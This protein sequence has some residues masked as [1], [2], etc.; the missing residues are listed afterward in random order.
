MT[1]VQTC[2]LPILTGMNLLQVW[3]DYRTD[4]VSGNI[5]VDNCPYNS[6]LIDPYFKKSDLSDC[7]GLW[8]RS[9]LTKREVLSLLPDSKERIMGITVNDSGRDGKFQFMPET[10]G[11]G[12]KNLLA[13]DEFYYRSFRNQKM[14]IDSDKIGRAS[15]RERV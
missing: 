15:C 14:L 12:I 9:F 10:L 11:F 1:G 2:A 4:P 7:N 13:Y 3:V 8:K 6:F 5:R